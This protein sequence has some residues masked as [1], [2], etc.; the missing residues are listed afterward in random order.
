[1]K[2]T[3]A[4]IRRSIGVYNLTPKQFQLQESKEL[5]KCLINGFAGTGKTIL[6]KIKIVELLNKGEKCTAFVPFNMKS[7]FEELIDRKKQF[8]SVFTLTEKSVKTIFLQHLN[9]GRNIFIDDAQHFYMIQHFF[10]SEESNMK[11]WIENFP[12]KYF[13]VFV[14]IY[15]FILK[16]PLIFQSFSTPNY[17]KRFELDQLLRNSQTIGK[18]AL[19]FQERLSSKIFSKSISYLQDNINNSQPI[20]DL[21]SIEEIPQVPKSCITCAIWNN[22]KSFFAKIH[23]RGAKRSSNYSKMAELAPTIGHSLT[24]PN[25]HL[26]TFKRDY[27][28]AQNSLNWPFKNSL[29]K[30]FQEL[31]SNGGKEDIL[32]NSALIFSADFQNIFGNLIES[33]NSDQTSQKLET[34]EINVEA[35]IALKLSNIPKSYYSFQTSSKEFLG[36][37]FYLYINIENATDMTEEKEIT[38]LSE[39]YKV[40]T[41][42]RTKLVII[43]EQKTLALLIKLVG[44]DI[45]DQFKI[46]NVLY[47]IW[48]NFSFAFFL[49][50][51]K[52]YK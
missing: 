19:R 29:E 40:I 8:L 28:N 11:K 51:F 5:R 23:L 15:Q 35:N 3:N 43:T 32:A 48:L 39:I 34:T 2:Q 42:A 10:S 22:I 49:F 21:K 9:E 36:V 47:F 4:N 41:R 31:S 14:D 46:E 18:I 38:Q 7:E 52:T 25:V 45:L 20:K 1:M 24:G 12:N 17:F 33:Q 37:I 30:A 27:L 6:A 13:W 44:K 16:G 50:C 26:F